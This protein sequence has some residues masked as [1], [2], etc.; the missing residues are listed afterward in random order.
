MLQR[1]TDVLIDLHMAIVK[2][3]ASFGQRLT[4]FKK[5]N[6]VLQ[7]RTPFVSFYEIQVVVCLR[8]YPPTKLPFCRDKVT[9]NDGQNR[10]PLK[11]QE[12]NFNQMETR[13][14]VAANIQNKS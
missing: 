8:N 6:I 2:S 3:S 14:R 1:I 4:S 13:T 9:L 7:R 12:L 11:Y 10:K 5:E